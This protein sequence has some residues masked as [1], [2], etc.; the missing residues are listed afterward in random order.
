MAVKAYSVAEVQQ[1]IR[2]ASERHGVSVSTM[3]GMAAI[4][5][6]FKWNARNPSGAT[7]V[8]QFMAPTWKDYARKGQSRM[9]AKANI[10]A[11]A[12]LLKENIRGLKSVL[13]REPTTG[14]VYLAHQQGLAGA[15]V[16]LANPT[17]PAW[18]VLQKFGKGKAR[19]KQN[20]PNSLRG[21][22]R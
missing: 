7:G 3:M 21:N 10:D 6:Q 15:K 4:E 5:S 11:G 18:E 8:Y 22:S 17:K 14:E 1:M 13:G 12:R 16:L 19:V 2:D 20:L 9:D